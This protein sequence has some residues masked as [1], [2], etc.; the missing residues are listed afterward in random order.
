MTPAI[1]LDEMNSALKALDPGAKMGGITYS[2]TTNNAL[3]QDEPWWVFM[4]YGTWSNYSQGATPEIAPLEEAFLRVLDQIPPG[5]CFLDFTYLGDPDPETVVRFFDDPVATRKIAAVLKDFINNFDP[6]H[7]LVIRY[8]VG[9]PLAKDAASDGF[10]VALFAQGLTNPKATLYYGNFSPTFTVPT[11][12]VAQVHPSLGHFVEG[13]WARIVAAAREVA[14]EVH[15]FLAGIDRDTLDGWIVRHLNSLGIFTGNWNHAKMFAANG[16]SLVQGGANYWGEYATGF[17]WLFD[18]SIVMTGDAVGDAHRFA[19]YMWHYLGVAPAGDPHV[20]QATPLVGVRPEFKSAQAPMYSGPTT[21][22]GSLKALAVGKNGFGSLDTLAFPAQIVDALRDFH[23]SIAAAVATARQ[24]PPEA[25]PRMVAAVSDDN[26]DYQA[27]LAK[28]GLAPAYWASRHARNLA[29][30]SARRSV[31][32]TQQKLVLDD[33]MTDDTEF[34]KLVH[35]INDALDCKWDGYVRPWD[36]YVALVTALATM[37]ESDPASI[38]GVRIV[39]SWS[40]TAE[41][42]YEDF[43]DVPEF[44]QQ[45]ADLMTGM[46]TLGVI[47]FAGPADEVVRSFLTYKRISLQTDRPG[48]GNHS[49]VV[50]VDGSL[51]YVGSDNAYPSYNA[52]FGFWFDDARS[53]GNYLSQYWDGDPGLWSIARTI[54]QS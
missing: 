13:L 24:N 10:V 52:E 31:H 17:P 29:V 28:L 8:L 37:S 14:D 50:V 6:D 47:N 53:I 2:L 9:D 44:H 18:T 54:S 5:D 48:H 25:I 21:P 46:R 16:R 23:L 12:T 20:S 15:E 34:P 19:D 22:T 51:M 45:L 26:P 42:G 11:E 1:T 30:R 4:P 41:G 40:S 3:S 35:E 7:S 33:L 43:M 36:F 49:K 38:P 32:L 27:H 39:C